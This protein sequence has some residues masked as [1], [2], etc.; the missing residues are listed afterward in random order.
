VRRRSLVAAVIVGAVAAP[1]AGAVAVRPGYDLGDADPAAPAGLALLVPDAGPT[2]SEVRARASLERGQVRNSLHGG[3]P[4]GPRLIEVRDAAAP[5]RLGVPGMI[6]GIPE[7]GEQPNDRRYLVLLPASGPSGLLVSR[8]TRI[9]GLVS[10]VD[11]APTVLGLEG[12]LRLSPH[13]DP[14]GYLRDLD[15]RIRDNGTARVPAAALALAAILV[16]ALVFPRAAVLAFATAAAANLLLGIAGVSEPWIAIPAIGVG[17]AAAAPL[18]LAARSKLAVGLVL[19]GTIA[20]YLVALAADATWVALSPLGPTQNARF[21]G[22]SN[23][24]ATML[25]VA[26]LAA[27]AFLHPR[28]GWAAFAGVG[29]LAL[30]TVGGSRFGADGGGAVVLAAGLAVLAVALDGG[31]GRVW[32]MAGAGAALAVAL[33]ALDALVGPSTHVGRSV[34]G[35]PGEVLGDVGDRLVLSWERVTAGPAVALAVALA[36]AL[37]LV[38]VRRGPRRPLP[39]AFAVALG[40]SLLVNDSPLDVAVGGAAALLALTRFDFEER[41]L[42]SV[43]SSPR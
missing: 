24:L 10:A 34:R 14:V 39:L 42:A 22:L 25:L 11:V 40:I 2:T 33:V 43:E 6:V 29:A 23:L 36:L 21:Y 4:D 5:D 38:L 12:R 30:V 27:A 16:L 3:L 19:A 20:A 41:A 13:P 26:A 17:A 31:R 28:G 37:V 7:G 15:A 9:P 1:A 8:S 32:L 35:G 18:A